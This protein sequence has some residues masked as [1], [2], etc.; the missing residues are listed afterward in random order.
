MA[1]TALARITG[2][3]LA[4][5]EPRRGLS[6]QT[7]EPWE[8]ATANVLVA[9]QN[10]TS[11]QLPRKVD[12]GYPTLRG[13]APVVGEEVDLLVEMSVYNQ[14]IQARVLSDFPEDANIPSFSA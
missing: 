13:G 11:V 8:I 7:G 14:D 6:K 5:P 10:V 9:A 3:V 4:L 12:G 1:S 2:T